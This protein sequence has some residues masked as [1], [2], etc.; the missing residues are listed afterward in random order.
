[1]DAVRS[2]LKQSGGSI[3][4][5]LEQGNPFAG[6]GCMSFY[7]EMV[8]KKSEYH[9]NLILDKH[10]EEASSLKVAKEAA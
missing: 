7:W 2:F 4:L 1:M 9:S 6:P 3:Q 5:C 10:R 8:F